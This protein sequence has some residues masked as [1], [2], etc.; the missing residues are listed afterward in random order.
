MKSTEKFVSPLIEQ[1]FPAVYREEGPMLVAFIKSYYEWMEEHGNS[2]YHARRLPDY[3]DIDTTVEDFIVH[4]KEKYLK[5][6]QFETSSNKRLFIKNAIPF[7][8]AKGTERS[9]DLFFKLIYG[10][11]AKLY[12]PGDD[13]FKLSDGEWIVPTYLELSPSAMNM[14]FI[15]KQ[16][17]GVNSG[18]VAFV[19]DLVV[20]RIKSKYIHVFYI[21]NIAGNFQYDEIVKLYNETAVDLSDHPRTI[22]SLTEIEVIDGG[23]GFEIG[24]TVNFVSAN[25]SFAKAVVTGTEDIEGEVQFSLND[26]G[27]GYNSDSLILISNNILTIS[28]VSNTMFEDFETVQ[29]NLVKIEFDDASGVIP[30]GVEVFRYDIS[31]VLVGSGFVVNRNQIANSGNVIITASFGDLLDGES[32]LFTAGNTLSANILSN[33][34]VNATGNIVAVSANL[35]INT[36]DRTGS[37][38]IGEQVYQS[39]G[40]VA[41][42]ANA[43]VRSVETSGDNMV[44]RVT[45]ATGVFLS[46][47]PLKGRISGFL[48][49]LQNYSVKVGVFN[50]INSFYPVNAEYDNIAVGLNSDANG[51]ISSVSVGSNATFKIGANST[52]DNAETANINLD[53]ITSGRHAELEFDNSDGDFTDNESIFRYFANGDVAAEGIVINVTQTPSDPNGSLLIYTVTGNATNFAPSATPVLTNTFYT[54]GNVITADIDAFTANSSYYPDI[55]LDALF[56]GFPGDPEANLTSNTLANILQFDTYTIGTITTFTDINPG[57]NYNDSPYVRIYE[58]LV[59]QYGYK[60]YGLFYNNATSNFNVGEIV[61]QANT[62]GGVEP[63]GAIGKVQSSNS[64]ALIVRRLLVANS[65]VTGKIIGLTSGCVANLISLES[66]TYSNSAGDNAVVDVSTATLGGSVTKLT[67]LSSGFGYQD[68]EIANFYL[69]DDISVTGSAKLSLNNQGISEGYY[70][71]N[72]GFVSS[73]KYIHDGFYYQ[74]YSYDVLAGLPFDRYSDMFK[75][76]LHVAGTMAFGS[77]DSATI[78]NSEVTNTDRAITVLGANGAGTLSGNST[79][80]TVEGTSTTFSTLFSNGNIVAISNGSIFHEKRIVQVVNNTVMILS[81]PL[82][83]TNT[84]ANYAKVIIN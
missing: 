37:F 38:S 29:Q 7:Y 11:P 1:M 28:N 55:P 78:A 6:I 10:I 39:N 70:K 74:E 79:S 31:D 49:N 48:A 56:Y 42:W 23:A 16:I 59:A 21:S 17:V 47:L 64:T 81:G 66:L 30:S 50:V 53:F 41:E 73:N 60:D 65:F 14:D 80:S 8:R 83:F 32:T 52:L 27:F 43:I 4:F 82:A 45:N 15:G 68:K 18:A 62:I 44:V 40:S 54:T 72:G 13:L 61:R 71:E 20:K 36:I 9:V 24:Q 33:T 26:G 19:E 63:N 84:A 77:Y 34:A 5:N 67:P 2:L 75:K 35:T 25:G 58:P 51:Y 46:G 3:R 12:Y 76:V 69:S 57:N 22:G